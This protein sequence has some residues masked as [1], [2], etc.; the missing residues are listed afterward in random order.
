MSSGCCTRSIGAEG[1]LRT[2][3]QKSA[4]RTEARAAAVCKEDCTPRDRTWTAA[5]HTRAVHAP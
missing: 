5:A 4:L 3:E 1:Q 2:T